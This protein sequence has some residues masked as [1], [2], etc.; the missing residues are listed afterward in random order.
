MQS[1]LDT[2][3]DNYYNQDNNHDINNQDIINNENHKTKD[4]SMLL[5]IKRDDE[6]LMSIASKAVK[7][8]TQDLGI[9]ILLQPEH[10][11][12]LKHYFGVDNEFIDLFEVCIWFVFKMN[13]LYV[14]G[15]ALLPSHILYFVFM[16]ASKCA[17]I[18]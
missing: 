14:S 2:H 12:K 9:R 6:E 7:E 13:G 16:I 3:N 18:R 10:A 5:L 17:W 15:I 8:L 1:W 11:A 4:R